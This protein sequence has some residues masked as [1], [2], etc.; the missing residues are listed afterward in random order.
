MNK[1]PEHYDAGAMLLHWAVALLIL[2]TSLSSFFLNNA[3]SDSATMVIRTFHNVTGTLALG[4]VIAWFGWRALHPELPKPATI[5]SRELQFIEIT[6]GALNVLLL[7]VPVTGIL[8]LFALGKSIDIGALKLFYAVS[9]SP[10]SLSLLGLMHNVLGKL[11]L[12]IALL[13]SVHALW[14]HFGKRDE[15]VRRMLPWASE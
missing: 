8:Y 12:A 15:R 11:I 3:L 5:G 14:R 7:L 4:L 6:N 13:H 1:P 9:M 2:C 10:Q